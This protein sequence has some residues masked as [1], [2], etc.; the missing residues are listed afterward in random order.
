MRIG[1]IA[2][3]LV[4]AGLGLALGVVLPLMRFE[5][6]YVFSRDASLV[7]IV[8]SLWVDGDLALAVLV[9]LVSIVFPTLK[10]VIVT[11]E[12]LA[13]AVPGQARGNLLAR[14]MPLVSR[15]SMMD[16]LLVAIVIFAAKAGRLAEAFTQPGLWFYAGSSVIVAVL[17]HLSTRDGESERDR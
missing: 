4:L 11:A 5:S 8:A 14:S 3:L 17:P 15:W 12:H 2:T 7:E 6:L 1:L 10:L 9:A 16:V 13:G